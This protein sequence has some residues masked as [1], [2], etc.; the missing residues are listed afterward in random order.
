MGSLLVFLEGDRFV[1]VMNR[2]D[3]I[4]RVEGGVREFPGGVLAP[5]DVRSGGSWIGVNKDNVAGF[6]LNRYDEC[7][8]ANKK[9]RGG[10]VL[11][12]LAQGGFDLC[13][14]Y[15]GK[16]DLSCYMPFSLVLCDGKR[17]VKFDFNGVELLK[18][19]VVLRDYYVL[20]SSSIDEDSVKKWRY[21]RFDEWYHGDRE[22]ING[23]P[24]F[25]LLQV[26]GKEDYS[27]MVK[28]SK[29]STLSVT[30]I[31]FGNETLDMQ[32][33]ALNDIKNLIVNE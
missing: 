19:E 18:E 1:A 17:L 3:D 13:V 9:S 32:Y 29:V 24:K 2:D 20:T 21:D 23:L 4:S 31:L 27:V 25:N 7:S 28:R 16:M 22:I 33:L 30:K 5:I 6:L 8:L 11:D 15:V 26:V 12:V 14:S 10:I